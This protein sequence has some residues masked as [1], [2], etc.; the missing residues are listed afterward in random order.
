MDTTGISVAYGR[1]DQRP[2]FDPRGSL[3]IFLYYNR[4]WIPLEASAPAAFFT[5]YRPLVSG[6]FR[7][8]VGPGGSFRGV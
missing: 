6:S 4:T 3:C 1:P 5:G 7:F 8:W 2:G